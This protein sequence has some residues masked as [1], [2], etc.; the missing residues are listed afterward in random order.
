ML[1]GLL[2]AL[3]LTATTLA[4]SGCGGSSKAA[5][6]AS[7]AASTTATT[8][9]TAPATDATP[10]LAPATH[11]KVA[12]GTPL[13]RVRFI[14]SADAICARAN[15]KIAAVSVVDKQELARA[16]PQTAVYE[17]GEANQLTK[18]VP[19]AA[20]AHDWGLIIS[21]FHRYSEYANVAARDSEAKNIEAAIPLFQPAARIHEQL[22]AIA[23]HDGFKHCS[24]LT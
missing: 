16:F 14:A 22:D 4:A 10:Q 11:V 18:L 7:T 20:M 12:T 17:A 8:S 15:T 19:P 2:G 23:K 3:A 1:H 9:A 13:P 5:S 21:D 6:T 24:E